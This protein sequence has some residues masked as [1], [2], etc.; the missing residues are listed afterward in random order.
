MW[1]FALLDSLWQRYIV[2]ASIDRL[3][4]EP[5]PTPEDLDAMSDQEIEETLTEA[6]KLRARNQIR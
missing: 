6:R 4:A 2:T 5:Q 1:T 3:G